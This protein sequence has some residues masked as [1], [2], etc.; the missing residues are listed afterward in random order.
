LAYTFSCSPG[1]NDPGFE[2][3]SVTDSNGKKYKTIEIGDQTWMAENLNLDVPGSECYNKDVAKCA[4]YGRLYDWETAM[5]LPGCNSAFCAWQID[6]KHQGI[7]PDGWHIPSD[8]DWDKLLSYVGGSPTA[9]RYLKA[10]KGWDSYDGKPGNGEDKYGFSALPG[11]YLDDYFDK[12]KDVGVL[13]IWWSTSERSGMASTQ[14]MISG[15]EPVMSLLSRKSELNSVRCLQGS[16]E[17]SSSSA[18]PSSG[19]NDISNYRIEKIGNQT[20]MAEN[21]NYNVSG[22]VCH[23]DDPA[24]TKYGR[25]Y[26]WATAMVLHTGCNHNSCASQIKPKHQGICPSG[27]HI[28]N[29]DDWNDLM[30]TVNPDCSGGTGY[31]EGAGTKLKLREGWEPYSGISSGTDEFRFS[32]L[33]GGYVDY[34][35]R[36]KDVGFCGYWWSA[37]EKYGGMADHWLMEYDDENLY[38]GLEYKYNL[39]SVRCVKD[40]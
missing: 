27:W 23:D 9:G 4:I 15:I 19:D 16:S 13:G 28:P 38:Y 6:A 39:F 33:P 35:G 11:G 8:E 14:N 21:L 10:A 17:P 40:D 31:C 26:D 3:G 29:D 12:F 37:S 1:S 34:Y 20:W 25:L 22:S 5:K 24:C 7:C 18:S 36:L 2:Y 30:E 32:A